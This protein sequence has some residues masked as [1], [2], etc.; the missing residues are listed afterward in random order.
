MGEQEIKKK[1]QKKNYTWHGD[2]GLTTISNAIKII[3]IFY[4]NVCNKITQ[5]IMQEYKLEKLPTKYTTIFL[6]HIFFKLYK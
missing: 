1:E 4:K 6:V 3:F 5:T 2:R